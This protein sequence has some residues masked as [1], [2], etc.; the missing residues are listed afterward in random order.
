MDIYLPPKTLAAP[1]GGF[2]MVMYIHGG[3]W[4]AG[5]SHS[6]VPF[7]DF[8]GVLANIA[9][10]GYVVTSVNYRLSGEAIWPAQAQDIKAAIKFLRLHAGKYQ[11]NPDR[12]MTWGVSAGGHL[13]AIAGVTCGAPERVLAVRRILLAQQEGSCDNR[14]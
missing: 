2:P 3:G 10:R 9:A 8:P 11:I 1:A 7:V 6:I 5:N 14:Q 13:S 12:F 4:M